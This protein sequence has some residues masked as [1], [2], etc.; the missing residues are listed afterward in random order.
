MLILLILGYILSIL[1]PKETISNNICALYFYSVIIKSFFT[2]FSFI[3]NYPHMK[4]MSSVIKP[5]IFIFIPFSY[6]C[7]Y[8]IEIIGISSI[9]TNPL[10]FYINDNE[11]LK[12]IAKKYG[13]D[14]R[15][16]HFNERFAVF[17][18]LY[19]NNLITR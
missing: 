4:T 6:L 2:L 10:I 15:I 3:K 5:I 9:N 13:K 19:R 8:F 16:T 18:E 12:D 17:K 11:T 14:N 7:L 1:V